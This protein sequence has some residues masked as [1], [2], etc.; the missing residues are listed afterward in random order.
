MWDFQNTTRETRAEEWLWPTVASWALL[1]AALEMTVRLAILRRKQAQAPDGPPAAFLFLG[2]WMCCYHFMYYDV[3]LGLMG[4]VL[5]ATEPRRYLEPL[6]LAIIPLRR[7][8]LSPGLRAYHGP[9]L[10]AER[11]PP[12]PLLQAGYRHLFVLNRMAPSMFVLL[13][14]VQYVFP[15]VGLG[16]H[17]GPPWDTFS[18]MAIWAWCGWQWLRHGDKVATSWEQPPQEPRQPPPL[19]SD[20]SAE[21][22]GVLA[23]LP[24]STP[25]ALVASSGSPS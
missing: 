8:A 4:L 11:L 19:R 23:A 15:H 7:G 20:L 16:N 5:L 24:A 18:L 10:P 6:L 22:D 25:R 14:A 2:A 3:L 1:G 9:N 12:V 13:L 21:R 17:W